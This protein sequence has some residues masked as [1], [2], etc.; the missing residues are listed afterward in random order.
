VL[1]LPPEGK[2]IR[3]YPQGRGRNFDP[4]AIEPDWRV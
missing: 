1:R 3:V 2:G 4:A